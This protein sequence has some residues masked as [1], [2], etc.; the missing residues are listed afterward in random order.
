VV[1]DL[2]EAFPG[3]ESRPEV[4]GGQVCV[5]RTGI[6]V[7]FLVQA[8]RLGTSDVGNLRSFPT[9]RVEDLANA[10]AYA[11]SHAEEIDQQIRDGVMAD[12]CRL[13]ILQA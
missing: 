8:W 3:V 6:P 12:Y 13:Q 1:Q 7:W 9:L 10:W 4:G 5:V 11:R 2:G